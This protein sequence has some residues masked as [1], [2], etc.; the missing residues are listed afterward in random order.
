MD[1][2]GRH[3]EYEHTLNIPCGTKRDPLKRRCISPAFDQA[4]TPQYTSLFLQIFLAHF[5]PKGP[6]GYVPGNCRE[7]IINGLREELVCTALRI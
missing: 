4:Y 1:P 6:L 3:L 5:F 7:A 2:G